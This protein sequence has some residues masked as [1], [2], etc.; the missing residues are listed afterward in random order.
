MLKLFTYLFDL[1]VYVV[2]A[3]GN[4]G[5]QE[6]R[7]FYR[8]KRAMEYRDELIKFYKPMEY[9]VYFASRAIFWEK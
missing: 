8:L 3:Y 1:S 9:K 6:S 2:I 4:D 5:V 7:V